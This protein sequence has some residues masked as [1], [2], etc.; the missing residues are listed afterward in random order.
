MTVRGTSTESHVGYDLP[1]LATAV[2]YRPVP[3]SLAEKAYFIIRDRIVSLR[4]PPG[5]AINERELTAEL[6][7]GRTP[8]REAVRRL[9]LEKLVEV[10]PRRGIFV[11]NVDIRD[12]GS[13]SEVRAELESF[14]ARLAAERAN[15]AERA[16]CQDLISELDAN[17]RETDV[18][19]LIDVDQRI[20][21]HIYRCSHNDFLIDTLETYFVLTLRPWFMVLDRVER[22][23]EAVQEHRDLLAAILA[24]DGDR[25]EKVMR[26]H[27]V[28]FEAAIRKVL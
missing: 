27:V 26:Q 7:L 6:G 18:R 15:T 5:S 19:R 3:S 17:R 16:T 23:D 20:H 24:G 12:L 14:A 21:R 4:L 25:A 28:G 22:L 13:V 2:P 1:E 8:V 9:M 11:S 10:Y